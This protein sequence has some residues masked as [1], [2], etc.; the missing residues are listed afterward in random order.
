MLNDRYC[1]LEFY[2]DIIT[3]KGTHCTTQYP[4]ASR[5]LLLYPEVTW[6]YFAYNTN[7]HPCP[8]LTKNHPNHLAPAHIRRTKHPSRPYPIQ[9]VIWQIQHGMVG[10]CTAA[11][12]V[13]PVSGAPT[14]CPGRPDRPREV[15]E[16]P[17]RSHAIKGLAICDPGH[18]GRTIRKFRTDKFDAW[19]KRKLWLMQLMWTAGSQPFT[20]VAR[21]KI[22]VCFSHRSYPFETFEFFCWCIRGLWPWAGAGRT[23]R[24]TERVEIAGDQTGS[25]GDLKLAPPITSYW[26]G[27]SNRVDEK[28][29]A[30]V[31]SALELGGNFVGVMKV[32][33]K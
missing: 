22:S 13:S 10:T 29:E 6:H 12:P 16:R 15:A 20:W 23:T 9:A 17:A 26:K 27:F 14:L 1:N 31:L 18:M 8:V 5:C 19:N 2:K 32:Y 28:R 21:V 33:T 3:A 4:F 24:R 7:K 30:R 25:S 11:A